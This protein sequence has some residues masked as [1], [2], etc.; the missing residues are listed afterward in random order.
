MVHAGAADVRQRAELGKQHL[1]RGGGKRRV[2]S[3]RQ[4]RRRPLGSARLS[5]LRSRRRAAGRRKLLRSSFFGRERDPRSPWG[6]SPPAVVQVS[7]AQSPPEKRNQR[8]RRSRVSSSTGRKPLGAQAGTGR[9]IALRGG[10][11]VRGLRLRAWSPPLQGPRWQERAGRRS[12]AVAGGGQTA[13]PPS[14]PRAS[15]PAA[16]PSRLLTPNILVRAE[17]GERAENIPPRGRGET[18]LPA[19]P[20]APSPL[21]RSPRGAA[22]VTAAPHPAPPHGRTRGGRG[23][24]NYLICSNRRA[25]LH[26][27]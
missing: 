15:E 2:S 7:V 18:P 17:C 5:S 21:R 9:T 19:V 24:G 3:P 22:A 4:L 20:A 10:R 13:P 25:E 8:T 11:Q 14:C 12:G 27:V 16:P 6:P 1:P 23:A 26:I